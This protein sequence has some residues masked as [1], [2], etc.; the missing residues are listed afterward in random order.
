M[1]DQVQ[2]TLE[3][4]DNENNGFPSFII[5]PNSK[6]KLWWDGFTNIFFIINY[7]VTPFN[8]AV[9]QPTIEQTSL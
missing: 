7:F 3:I 2:E 8:L 5:N 4:N 6:T 9:S 1:L